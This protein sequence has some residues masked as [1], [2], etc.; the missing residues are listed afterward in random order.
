MK[1]CLATRF[2]DLRNGGV[3]RFSIEIRDGLRRRGHN[4]VCVS[5][6]GEYTGRDYL[7]N[8]FYTMSKALPIDCDVYHAMTPMESLYLPK[9]RSV[10]TIHD[11]I[12][13]VHHETTRMH[14]GTGLLGTIKRHISKNVF[15]IGVNAS[16]KARYVV[17]DSKATAGDLVQHT[18]VE[19]SKLKVIHPGIAP[20]LSPKA[21]P[22]SVYR[23]GTL[24]VLVAR[25]RVDLL[26]RAFLEADVR[27]ELV[28]AGNGP[29]RE[30]LEGIANGDSRVR[31]LGYLP[32]E[33]LCDFY[34]S[35]DLFVFPTTAEGYGLPIVEA[36][37]CGKPAVV[38]A[39]S[40]IPEEVRRR[41]YISEDLTGLFTEMSAGNIK[42]TANGNL[43]FARSHSW[44]SC[45]AQYLSLY[46]EIAHG[47][48]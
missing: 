38:L 48:K 45:V 35:L 42:L 24:S 8:S 5:D 27:G 29:D 9:E 19:P 6:P 37:A 43:G 30:R 47:N 4:V 3:G 22:D 26:I 25:K 39:D 11:I 16:L 1:I 36:M 13:S 15:A 41:C 21:K 32:D 12:Q 44:E 17:A 23:I 33:G 46:E 14:Y 18:K 2:F 34:N 28:I 31:F 10:V 20:G 7:K 40:L